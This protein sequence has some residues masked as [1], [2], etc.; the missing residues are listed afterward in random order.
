MLLINLRL[1]RF[2]HW[3]KPTALQ[4]RPAPPM[5]LSKCAAKLY[6]KK[7]RRQQHNKHA[8]KAQRVW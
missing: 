2:M 6:A 7:Y 1:Q 4:E 3:K 8:E 5:H